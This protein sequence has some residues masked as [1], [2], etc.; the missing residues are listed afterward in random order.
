MKKKL[1]PAILKLI[2]RAVQEVPRE[3]I[4]RAA[5]RAVRYFNE[6]TR[7]YEKQKKQCDAAKKE[8]KSKAGRAALS[9]PGKAPRWEEFLEDGL[10]SIPLSVYP[11]EEI[12]SRFVDMM[13]ERVKVVMQQLL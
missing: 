9:S 5:T 12:E 1:S 13:L 4:E 2:E 8:I 7:R 3:Y 10:D 11:G 6:E